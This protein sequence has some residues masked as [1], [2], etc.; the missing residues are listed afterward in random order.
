MI[1]TNKNEKMMVVKSIFLDR[2]SDFEGMD[3]GRFDINL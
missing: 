3:E 1:S 2:V